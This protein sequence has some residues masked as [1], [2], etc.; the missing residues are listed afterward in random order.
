MA[1]P[2]KARTR[3]IAVAGAGLVGRKHAD[4]AAGEGVLHA[5]IDPVAGARELAE[6][7]GCLWY[8]AVEDYL[9]SHRPDGMIIATPNQLHVEHGLACVSHGV[10]A[11]IEKPIADIPEAA[12]RLVRE[13]GRFGVPILVGH[14]R[15]HNPIVKAAKTA[16]ESGALGRIV[17]VHAQFWLYK[18][19]DYF[20]PAWRRAKGAGPVFINLIHDID[21]LRH[22]CGEIV[23][24]QAVESNLTRGH[25]VEDSAAMLLTFEN[26]ALGTVSVS[27][28]I[29]APWSWELTAAENPA[30]P[31][32]K[33]ACYTIGGQTGSLSI[34][35]L[36]L[37][38]YPGK[39]G[40]WEPID[41]RTLP[42][43]PADPLLRQ[44]R[45]FLDVI[46]GSAQPL[47]NGEEG[48]RTLAVIDAIKEAALMGTAQ[49]VTLR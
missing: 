38:S 11:L 40:W 2:I 42:V 36:R 41:S 17:S 27:D 14:H 44:F 48:L 8:P 28:T 19:D 49:Q 25:E 39:P 6:R 46:D 20:E 5:I 34:P 16:I 47:V 13:A 4:M 31:E 12:A 30:Y 9:A 22:F 10:P 18:P 15:R 29:P 1:G 7:H 33:A 26:G 24:V 37:W 43:E 23:S 3:R 32:T 35:D 21:L 45:H